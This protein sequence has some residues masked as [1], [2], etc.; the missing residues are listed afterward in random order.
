MH[1]L[2]I[3]Q[4]E[5]KNYINTDF[6][7]ELLDKNC[8]FSEGPLWNKQGY[9]LFSDIPN[10]VINKIV[11]GTA[12]EIYL[13]D[14]GC[15]NVPEAEH[16]WMMGSNGLTYDTDGNLLL[17]QHG[18]HAVAKYDGTQLSAFV[19]S[20]Q[21]KKLNSPNDIIAGKDGS[22]YFSDP[23]YGLRDQ[24]INSEKY[25]PLAGF[26]CWRNEELK[27]FCDKYQYPNGLCL[28]PDGEFLYTCSNKPFEAFVLE[29]YVKDLSQK[30]I[31][32]QENSDGIKCDVSGNLYL[33]N[34]DGIIIVNAKGKRIGL[35]QLSTIPANCCWGGKGLKDLFIC[36]RENIF[37]IRD[38]Q[39]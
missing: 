24:K 11:P 17:C 39:K 7:V 6:E 5:V 18:D 30:R 9:Y 4:D 20:Y 19:T 38:L 25:Q 10:N 22:V 27:L 1:P 33:C 8:L 21:G 37:L 31:V 23:P 15:S 14:S 16:P 13:T 28:S 3:Y 36:A 35:I 34:K 29:F 26:Y 32:C 2:I 12:K